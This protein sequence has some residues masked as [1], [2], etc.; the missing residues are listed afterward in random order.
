M[1]TILGTAGPDALTSG[2]AD[3]TLLGLG[4]SD[5][6]IGGGG[7]DSLSGSDGEDLLNGG[8]GADTLSGGEGDD[9]F[10]IRQGDTSPTGPDI[11]TDWSS[12]DRFSLSTG[13]GV[14]QETSAPDAGQTH[15]NTL[16]AAGARFVAVQTPLGVIIY[17]DTAVN[18]GQ[19]E[20][21]VL[22][23]GRTLDD[24]SAINLGSA[25]T[26]PPAPMGP[27]EPTNTP[28][29][30]T[31]PT[32]PTPPAPPTTPTTPNTPTAPTPTAPIT[33]TLPPRTA[34]SQIS[35]SGDMDA[36]RLGD[37][38][39]FPVTSSSANNF[40]IW[41][42]MQGATLISMPGG[43]TFDSR[44]SLTGG[45]ITR[46]DFA[47]NGLGGQMS[48]SFDG[49]QFMRW[50]NTNAT[51]EAF[52]TLFAGNDNITGG[53]NADVLRGFAGSDLMQGSGGD[54]RLFG[55]EGNDII[56]GYAPQGVTFG[57]PGTNYLRGDEGDDVIIG[58]GLFDD[59][60]GN[61][62]NDTAVGGRGDDWVVGGRDNDNL[63]GEAGNDL[64]YGNLGNDTCD[65]GDGN[66]I[67]RGG[68]GDDVVTAGA[69]ADF[70]SGDLGSDTLSG[71]AG[72]D[73]FNTFAETG[74]DRVL[75]FSIAD[76]DRVQVAPGTTFTLAQVGADTVISMTGGGQMILVGVTASSLPTG[77]IFGA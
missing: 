35:I 43:L 21:A 53:P 65:G 51:Q 28:P 17:M 16:I 75:D 61:M 1:S 29:T 25:D 48:V 34:T 44:G 11:I 6:L 15:A 66:D 70:V 50:V 59:I 54:N 68:Q 5:T 67:V 33:P 2:T 52:A 42:G 60:N 18:G 12:E 3:D 27:P 71:G 38:A 45:P 13:P 58:G 30:P 49:S 19:A 62:G 64:V 20:D 55:G 24:I 37:L 8:V 9:T 26:L 7:R 77:W 56:Y 22:L 39:G 10:V 32:T 31:A 40:Q 46:M 41:R 57:E 69:G 47:I 63:W 76:G 14:Y 72:A 4:G 73:I 74:L 23:A 36:A